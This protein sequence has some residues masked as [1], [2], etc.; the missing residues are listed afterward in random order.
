MNAP[1]IWVRYHDEEGLHAFDVATRAEAAFWAAHLIER[2]QCT[3][4]IDEQPPEMEVAS[5]EAR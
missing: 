4:W 1:A 3:A 2:W 5:M